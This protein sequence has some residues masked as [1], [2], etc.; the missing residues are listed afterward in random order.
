MFK[1][2]LKH[3]A[4]ISK[5]KIRKDKPSQAQVVIYDRSGSEIL[6]PYLRG[7]SFDILD[8]RGES[9]N[10]YCLMRAPFCHQF[11]M[12][13]FVGAYVFVYISSVNPQLIITF[14]ENNPRFWSLKT[15]FKGV[16]TLFVQNGMRRFEFI[17]DLKIQQKKEFWVDQMFVFDQKSADAYSS[18][19]KGKVTQIGSLKNN[20]CEVK[21]TTTP[22]HDILFV[23]QWYP[24]KESTVLPGTSKRF[25]PH[26]FYLAEKLVLQTVKAWTDGKG[27]KITVLGRHQDFDQSALE[28]KFFSDCIGEDF[29]FL[30]A[31]GF[32]FGYKTVDN[33]SLIC[34]IDSAL[35]YE[36]LARGAKCAIF[37]C[38]ENLLSIH[39]CNKILKNNGFF[40]SQGCD[41]NEI[42]RVL[43]NV[44]NSSQASWSKEVSLSFSGSFHYDAGNTVLAE[45]LSNLLTPE[46]HV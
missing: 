39:D 8:C 46:K 1:K 37:P 9:I 6:M 19:I 2:L 26:E 17:N 4:L 43:E 18:F 14:I 44:Y 22:A 10:L 3:L 25:L 12:G 27:L 42:Y 28:E 15:Q 24:I 23:S 5:A 29:Y 21:K 16:T 38:R 11:W 41:E 40:W 45:A 36:A 32:P 33:S 13:D 30:R 7:A 34:A 31:S 20:L 35:A